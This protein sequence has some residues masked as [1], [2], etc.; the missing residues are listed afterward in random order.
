MQKK[1][2]WLLIL[3]IFLTLASCR[4]DLD[5][6]IRTHSVSD[7]QNFVYDAMQLFYLY[8][9]EKEVL[10]DNFFQNIGE[11]EAYLSRFDSPESLFE[12]LVYS[13]DRFSIIVSD[14]HELENQLDGISLNNGMDYGLVR[15]S[16]SGEVLGYVRYV[17]PGTSA[18]EAGLQRGMLFNR[19]DG[20]KID[21]HNYR[22]ILSPTRYKLGLV[23]YQNGRLEEG[24]EIELQK[25]EYTENPIYMDTIYTVSNRKVGYLVYNAFTQSFDQ[26]LNDVFG[27]F[28]AEHIQSLVIDLR[29][30]GGGS[31]ET[32][33]NLAGMV[34]GQFTGKLFV[35][36]VFNDN[37]PDEDLLFSNQLKGGQPLNSLNLDKVYVLTTK[38]TASAS[39]LLVN[40]LRPYIDVVQVGDYTT[41]KFQG[42]IMLYESPDFSRSAVQPGH[43][44]ALL[45]LILKT[46]NADGYTDYT[47][48][49]TPDIKQE[50]DILHLGEL[51]RTDEPLL[52]LALQ[53]MTGAAP[54]LSRQTR[55]VNN[56]EF[57]GERKEGQLTYRQMIAR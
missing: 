57:I 48:G 24:G 29:Y 56:F 26:D 16:E 7:T 6:Q 4:D 43:S 40:A 35:K 27:K 31:V 49:L 17:L 22:D 47:D 36:E 25:K 3:V 32:S 30:N 11:R 55:A 12:D 33:K 21:E 14:F 45:P 44:Y 37:F 51:G 9:A 15:I 18:E 19:I 38:S 50:E 1:S 46:V 34:T 8:K 41:G 28:K 39:E 2:S 13:K 54:L 5:D 20:V 53:D 42:S 23:T 52:Q 10:G